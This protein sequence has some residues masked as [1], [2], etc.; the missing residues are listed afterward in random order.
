MPSDTHSPKSLLGK[1]NRSRFLTALLQCGTIAEAARLAEVDRA[2]VYR[3]MTDDVYF[4]VAV[5]EARDI[6]I[7]ALKDVA[8]AR[9][10]D[11]SDV[12]LMFLIKQADPTYRESYR[13]PEDE[14]DK[15]SLR[16]VMN[17]IRPEA[18]T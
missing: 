2:N 7:E 8:Y 1:R 15:V 9:A 16:D 10:R 13:A 14:S 11:K 6:G 12:L 4:R 5:D 18:I 3:T 17:A